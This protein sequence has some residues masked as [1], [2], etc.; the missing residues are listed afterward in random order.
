MKLRRFI[1]LTTIFIF[2]LSFA[3]DNFQVLAQKQAD[4]TSK[5]GLFNRWKENYKTNHSVAYEAAKEYLRKYPNDTSENAQFLRKWVTAYEKVTTGNSQETVPTQTAEVDKIPADA[6]YQKAQSHKRLEEWT[7][8]EDE[9]R[10]AVLLEP[11]NAQYR[12]EFAEILVK[13]KKIGEAES[14]YKTLVSQF[15]EN[16]DYRIKL[17]RVL[18]EE[19]KWQEAEVQYSKYYILS[20]TD[21]SVEYADVLFQLKRFDEAIAIYSKHVSVP[22]ISFKLGKSYAALEKWD[23][24]TYSFLDAVTFSPDNKDYR[25]YLELADER[26]RNGNSSP[27]IANTEWIINRPY[28]DNYSTSVFLSFLPNGKVIEVAYGKDH[29]FKVTDVHNWEQKGHIIYTEF[30]GKGFSYNRISVGLLKE[31]KILFHPRTN[32]DWNSMVYMVEKAS[33]YLDGYSTKIE[34][35]EKD[36]IYLNRDRGVQLLFG[37]KYQKAENYFRKFLQANTF[38][39]HNFPIY[40]GLTISLANQGRWKEA[41]SLIES[42][43]KGCKKYC[44]YGYHSEVELENYKLVAERIKAKQKPEFD[45]YKDMKW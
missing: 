15:P 2:S 13:N 11:S 42:T 30:G 27:S 33:D 6:H 31:N 1:L 12:T 34:L 45:L 17:A 25:K 21:K 14:Q 19:Q 18:A 26:V 37:E 4:I 40:F 43:I 7:E 28:A 23:L 16:S 32:R 35:S 9:L 10:K 22:E 38:D 36:D 24:A 5:T 3:A 41:E 44:K 39:S 20:R 8:A 29:D